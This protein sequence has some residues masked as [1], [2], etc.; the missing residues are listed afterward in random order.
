MK[1][2][3]PQF[4]DVSSN[5]IP[6]ASGVLNLGAASLAYN[7]AYIDKVYLEADPSTPLQAATKNYVDNAVSGEDLWDR[8]GTN[9]SPKIDNDTLTVDTTQQES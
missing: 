7:N 2:Y 4:T 9:I 1:L 3:R 6:S 5:I 8:S